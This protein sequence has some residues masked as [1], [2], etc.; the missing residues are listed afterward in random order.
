MTE[1]PGTSRAG[2]F[3]SV[4]IVT[5]IATMVT[6]VAMTVAIVVISRAAAVTIAIMAMIANDAAAQGERGKQNQ[7]D[8]Q[9]TFHRD[10]VR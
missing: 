9:Q 3:H 10:L 6:V 5:V 8:K 4:M 7:C 1:K 2:L